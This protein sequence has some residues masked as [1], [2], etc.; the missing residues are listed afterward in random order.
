MTRKNLCK[1]W[2]PILFLFLSACQTKSIHNT[3][4]I[5]PQ[6]QTAPAPTEYSGEKQ[7]SET[8]LFN[9]QPIEPQNQNIQFSKLPKIG[10][11]LGPGGAKTFAHIG[12]LQELQKAKI[13]V[14]AVSGL[15]FA[16]PMAALYAWKGFA[17]DV[18]WQMFKI[19]EDEILKKG[20][21]SSTTKPADM[22]DMRDF[23]KTIFQKL[24]VEDLKKPFACPALNISKNQIYMMS[25]GSLDQLLPYC[26][27][28]PPL[29]R[30]YKNNVSGL[31]DLKLAADY[32]RAQG[33]QY[34]VLVNVL[35]GNMQKRPIAGVDGLENLLWAELA[36]SYARP[37]TGIDA[38][39][40]LNL[41]DYGIMDLPQKRE[42]MQKG[43]DL[44]VKQ[45]EA[46]SQRLGF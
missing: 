28:Y 11:I 44:S 8:P 30:A 27:P 45:I 19:K 5:R 41:E 13:P 36:T 42:I 23:I 7:T 34:I 22:T 12:V 24:K 38:T 2:I 16:A 26:W 20:L 4:M 10:L 39:I 1:L 25:R 15:E 40:S 32:L 18:E 29:F 35:S 14:F 33:A 31:R 17:N 46:L 3:G 43:A 37:Q 21:I 9:Q 6:P